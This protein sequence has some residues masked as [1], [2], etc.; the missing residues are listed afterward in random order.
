[1]LVFLCKL[2]P[3]LAGSLI[4][5]L[6]CGWFARQ[7]KYCPAPTERIVEKQVTVEKVVDNPEHMAR[8][9]SLENEVQGGNAAPVI[10]LAG[11]KANG[12]AIKSEDDFTVIEGIG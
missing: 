3:Y 2:W 4:G 12:I 7:L 1:M 11:A 10:D 5:W 9:A 8:L 6:L